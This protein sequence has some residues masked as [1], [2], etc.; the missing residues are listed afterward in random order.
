MF[1]ARFSPERAGYE[2]FDA[3]TLRSSSR[4]YSTKDQAQ[5]VCDR[6]NPPKVVVNNPACWDRGISVGDLARDAKDPHDIRS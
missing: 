4:I 3:V 1:T 5:R 6:L 2:I